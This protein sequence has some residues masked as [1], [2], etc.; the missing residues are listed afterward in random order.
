MVQLSEFDSK[1][2]N[3]MHDTGLN[4]KLAGSASYVASVNGHLNTDNQKT[5]LGTPITLFWTLD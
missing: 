4:V 3:K 5:L 1:N 2:W